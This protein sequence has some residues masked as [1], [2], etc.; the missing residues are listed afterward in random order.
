MAT[1]KRK[2]TNQYYKISFS[3]VYIYSQ[4]NFKLCFKK[5]KKKKKEMTKERIYHGLV[6]S[7]DVTF[8]MNN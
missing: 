1:S 6:I 5:K 2:N 7:D 4:I 8:I 3:K